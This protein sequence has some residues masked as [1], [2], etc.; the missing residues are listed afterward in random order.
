[1]TIVNT[2]VNKYKKVYDEANGDKTIKWTIVH[3]LS[4]DVHCMEFICTALYML[5]PLQPCLL[6]PTDI[7]TLSNK[8]LMMEAL[9][10]DLDI[11]AKTINYLLVDHLQ[12]KISGRHNGASWT[13]G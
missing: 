3:W 7:F 5:V 11:H 6:S 4:I 1:M 10:S 13:E 8:D 9:K 12:L 2:G